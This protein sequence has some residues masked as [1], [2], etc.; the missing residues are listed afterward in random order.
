MQDM[1]SKNEFPAYTNWSVKD[2]SVDIEAPI[3]VVD[4]MKGLRT[5]SESGKPA[6]TIFTF[7]AYDRESNTS[8]IECNP[9]TG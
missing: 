5:V 1:A 6:R 9:I 3:A 4:I 2:K 7:L 8:L